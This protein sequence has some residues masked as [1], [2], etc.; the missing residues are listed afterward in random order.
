M[1]AGYRVSTDHFSRLGWRCRKSQWE[2][3]CAKEIK[4][5]IKRHQARELLLKGADESVRTAEQMLFEAEMWMEKC[6]RFMDNAKN[7]RYLFKQF[8][9]SEKDGGSGKPQDIVIS[10]VCACG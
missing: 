7:R 9:R 1:L 2:V 4:G 3:R 5:A 10:R 6:Q 8:I